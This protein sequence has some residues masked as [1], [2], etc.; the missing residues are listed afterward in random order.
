MRVLLLLGV[1]CFSTGALAAEGKTCDKFIAALK[2]AVPHK[3]MDAAGEKLFRKVC[4][5]NSKKVIVTATD[6]L[7]KA[8]NDKAADKCMRPVK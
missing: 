7:R 4:K 6:C 5:R 3:K 1:L 2:A 8:K